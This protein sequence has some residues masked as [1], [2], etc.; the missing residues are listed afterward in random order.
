MKSHYLLHSFAAAIFDTIPK[1]IATARAIAS[2]LIMNWDLFVFH[3][4]SARYLDP[5]LTLVHSLELWV[6]W[7]ILGCRRI[8]LLTK[9]LTIIL[10]RSTGAP[11]ECLQLIRVASFLVLASH[12]SS[13]FLA[14]VHHP[15]HM[16]HA[17]IA[18]LNLGPEGLFRNQFLLAVSARFSRIYFLFRSSRWLCDLFPL[19]ETL[20]TLC[21]DESYFTLFACY[22]HVLQWAFYHC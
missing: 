6:C 15:L 5:I 2:N 16:A 11:E 14:S 22:S 1:T 19:K 12:F 13:A 8:P 7:G 18:V 21:K 10:I 3:F 17:T 9:N 4:F 20:L